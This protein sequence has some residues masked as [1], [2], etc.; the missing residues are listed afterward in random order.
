MLKSVRRFLVFECNLAMWTFLSFRCYNLR[1]I[2]FLRKLIPDRH[3]LRLLYHKI[4]AVIAALIYFFPADKMIVIGVTG[5]NGKTTTVNFIANILTT[6]G[7]KVGM[8]S[9]INF[10]VADKKWTNITKQSTISPFKLQRLLKRM[11]NAGC[12]Y[13][14]LEVTSHAITQSRIFGIN[15][16]VALITNVTADHTEYHGG[17]NS[18]L[19]E[20]GKLFEKVSKSKRKTGVPKVLVLNAD[21]KYYSFFNQFVA[22]MKITYGLKAATIYAEK[23][24]KKPEGSHFVMH[25]PNN[26]IPMELRLPGEFNISNALGAAAVAISLQVPLELVKKG[27]ED[28]ASVAGRFEHVDCGQPFSVVIDYAH[29]ADSLEKLLS[30]YRTLTPGRLFVVFGATGGGRDKSK[31]PIMGKIANDYADY[32]VLTDDDPYADDE[33]EIIEDVA[34][35]IPRKEG[36]NLWKIPDR[37]EAIRLALTLAKEGDSVIVSGKGAEEVMMVRGKKIPWS[38]R[39]VITELLEREIKVAI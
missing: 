39:Q 36:K 13:A 5:T 10:Q 16:D 32:I 22:D 19:A 15:F 7:H 24:E 26:A 8:T 30:L 23:I 17:F 20:K 28:T 25:I 34:K 29:A 11:V 1:M 33:W 27:L 31:R 18:Y 9:T 14:V 6:A 21:D 12:Q 38:D 3:P 2:N 37:R 35:G 4:R